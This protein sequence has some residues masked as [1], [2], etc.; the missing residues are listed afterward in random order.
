MAAP[1]RIRPVLLLVC[2]LTSAMV[3]GRGP[4]TVAAAATTIREASG[5]TVTLRLVDAS[6]AEPAS[7]TPLTLLSDNGIRCARAPCP[8]NG[9]AWKGTADARGLVDVPTNM[10]QASTELRTATLAGDL[11]DDAT[12]AD[13]GTWT[14]ELLPLPSTY[15][16]PPGPPRPLKLVDA[17]STRAIA[18]APVRFE[19]R[20]SGANSRLADTRSN[21]LG[22][23]FL[24]ADLPGGALDHTWVV[25]AGYQA[26]H[27]DFAWA[28]HRLL[29]TPRLHPPRGTPP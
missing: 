11:V 28:R 26:A 22:Y 15:E 21:T 20:R 24:P 18:D 19:L 29:L 12:P 14:V 4:A 10:I 27:V 2:G 25:V 16:T 23:V 13:D 8:T 1:H 6:T 7:N 5:P 9:R 3:G 17:L